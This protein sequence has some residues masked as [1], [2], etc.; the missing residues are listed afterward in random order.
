MRTVDFSAFCTDAYVFFTRWLT[1]RF[2]HHRMM[3]RMM[4]NMTCIQTDTP[5]FSSLYYSFFH[6]MKRLWKEKLF[7]VVIP[8]YHI[9]LFSSIEQTKFQK[10]EAVYVHLHEDIVSFLKMVEKQ[11]L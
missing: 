7:V 11:L 2:T 9:M 10:K 6:E 4:T 3:V 5:F 1:A 8:F